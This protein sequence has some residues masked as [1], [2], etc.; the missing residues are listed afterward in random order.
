MKQKFKM[1]DKNMIKAL[2]FVY[3]ITFVKC[4]FIHTVTKEPHNVLLQLFKGEFTVLMAVRSN[5]GKASIVKFWRAN[6][7]F[8]NQVDTLYY[9][10]KT[11]S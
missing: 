5:I 1:R 9:D 7:K 2:S 6:G 10:E 4:A 11:V 8:T 3:L